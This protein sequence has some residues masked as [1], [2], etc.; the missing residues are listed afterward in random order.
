LYLKSLELQG[1]KSFPDKTELNFDRGISAIV[2]P[3]GSGKSNIS[4][5]I[6]WVLG[7]QSSKALR[8]AKMEDVIF[9]GTQLRGPV[10]YAEVS[11]ILDNSEGRLSMDSSEVMVTRRYYRSGESE[12]Y[13]N[14]TS[15]RLKDVHELFM[16][17]GIGRDGYSMIGQGRIDEILSAKSSDRRDIFEEAA[18][19]SKFRYRKE[20]AER[21]LQGTEVN[22]VRINDKIAELELNVGPLREQ[23][24]TASRY[25][26]LR[27]ELRVLEVSVWMHSL[28]SLKESSAELLESYELLSAQLESESGLL[29]GLYETVERLTGEMRQKD[30]AAEEKRGLLSRREELLRGSESEIAVMEASA[31][32]LRENIARLEGEKDE[33]SGRAQSLSEQIRERENRIRET[34]QRLDET[35]E[36]LARLNRLSEELLSEAEGAKSTEQ[37]LV[38]R[39]QG[40]EGILAQRNVEKSSVLSAAEE[41]RVRREKLNGDIGSAGAV[42]DLAAAE[43]GE[44]KLE[45]DRASS[46][47]EE[48]KNVIAGYGIR[49][50]NRK[51]KLE[52]AAE[53]RTRLTMQ[54][55]AAENRVKLLSD[56]ERD[57]E[58][59]SRAVKLIMQESERGGLSGIDGPLSALIKVEDMYT[60]AIETAMGQTLQNI[61]VDDEQDGKAAIS[62][63]KRKDGGRATFLPVSAI[64]GRELNEKLTEEGFV[65]IAS[66]LVSC[67]GKYREI[68]LS[69]LGRTVV[70]T[71]MD[72]AIRMAKAHS[73]RFRIVTLDGQIIN[74]G[75]SMTG[76]SAGSGTGILSRTNELGALRERLGETRDKLTA[77]DAEFKELEREVSAAEYE[78]EV[79]AAEQRAAEDTA[80]KAGG[81]LESLRQRLDLFEDT[82][83]A[84]KSELAELEKRLDELDR[85]LAEIEEDISKAASSL[86][87]VV[88][89]I[90]ELGDA[91]SELSGR[92]G[93]AAERA[94]QLREERSGLQSERDA[95]GE[96]LNELKG[97]DAQY[98]SD[99][100]KRDALIAEYKLQIEEIN[101]GAAEKTEA[102][103]GISAECDGIRG[104]ISALV[105]E[106]LRLEAR[107]TSAEKESQEKN[108]TIINV[109]RDRGRLEQKKTEAELLEKQLLDKLWDTYGLTRSTAGEVAAVQSSISA[110]NRRIGELKR[111]ISGLGDVNIGAIEEYKRINERYGYLTAQRD[112]V[113][114][115]KNDLL[116]IIS[117]ITE[118][119]KEIFSEQFALINECFAQTFADLFGGGQGRLELE[120]EEDILGCGIEIRVQPPGKAL[121]TIT[122]LSGGEKAFVAIALYFAILK[123]RPTPFCVMDEIEAALDEVNVERFAQY[124]R[125][126]CD[127]TQF[128]VITHRRGTMEESDILYGVTMQSIGVSK[129]L[130]LNVNE[131]ERELGIHVN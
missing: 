18:G 84:M 97:M 118:K 122:L 52:Q 26:L 108:R 131:A 81:E 128:I 83:G 125:T 10:G 62:F 17:T 123:V 73:Y 64:R 67:D 119:M 75:G 57:Y 105:E 46:T 70:A 113:D 112:D 8:G 40:Y 121:K 99:I 30:I 33:Q 117:E 16:D 24:E 102:V 20:E 34:E 65:G 3:N 79:A 93:E 85:R 120:D 58:G 60:L 90:S 78:A 28:A 63:L 86:E 96:S 44:K 36:E 114:K 21:R 50:S 61:V 115:S 80:L 106:K 23:S 27:D 2:G 92:R 55:H 31:A 14:K 77:A 95:L 94:S 5:A 22:L 66:G 88:S 72:A 129:I 43:Y 116:N 19:I 98:S 29:T 15:V 1:F 124:M 32:N 130:S 39:R 4:D 82:S 89:R 41:L 68:V 38:L 12:Y 35:N 109:E 11:L 6:R 49:L 59:Y 69:S 54:H 101:S 42:R 103:K 13:L 76:G 127:K 111:E 48:L 110:A 45:L 56:M 104:E 107:R 71:D 25:L 91:G 74:A 100:G 7:E 126:Y 87:E 47:A 51:K 37:A 9:G 53:E